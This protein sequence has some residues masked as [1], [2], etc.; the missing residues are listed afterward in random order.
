M[1]L[2]ALVLEETA[3]HRNV[4]A[5]LTIGRNASGMARA[6]GNIT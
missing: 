5:R 1:P 4:P 2:A 3:I 6:S